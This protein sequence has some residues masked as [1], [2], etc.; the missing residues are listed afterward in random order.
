MP[1]GRPCPAWAGGWAGFLGFAVV[2]VVG[3]VVVAVFVDV[4][5]GAG[6]EVLVVVLLW[7]T[8]KATARISAPRAAMIAGRGSSIRGALGTVGLYAALVRIRHVGL[9]ALGEAYPH[10]LRRAST[11][12]GVSH[13]V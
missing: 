10:G 4:L 5:A 1:V 6:E 8:T 11:T 2:V 3:W 13:Q 9:D 7:V 12:N